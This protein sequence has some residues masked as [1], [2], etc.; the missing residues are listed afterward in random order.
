MIIGTCTEEAGVTYH[1]TTIL[2][3]RCVAQQPEVTSWCQSCRCIQLNE[4]NEIQKFDKQIY[5]Y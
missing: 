4:E 5:N 1:K 2:Q 3:N